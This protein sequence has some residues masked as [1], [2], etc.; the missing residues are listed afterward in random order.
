M[1]KTVEMAREAGFE[2]RKGWWVRDQVPEDVFAASVNITREVERFAELVRYDEREECANIFD[3]FSADGHPEML[4][5]KDVAEFLRSRNN[6]QIYS[7]SS[8]R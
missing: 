3:N 6:P 5:S 2:V 8:G 4:S 7:S 1:N